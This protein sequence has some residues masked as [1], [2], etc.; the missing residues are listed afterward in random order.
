MVCLLCIRYREIHSYWDSLYIQRLGW[1]GCKGCGFIHSHVSCCYYTRQC[2]QHLPE[3]VDFCLNIMEKDN[4]L[5]S[6]LSLLFFFSNFHKLKF[7]I[8]STL[9][10]SIWIYLKPSRKMHKGHQLCIGIHALI[11]IT[12]LRA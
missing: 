10:L 6:L 7:I 1:W 11:F 12:M 2:F 8:S 9:I 3:F 5:N 4:T